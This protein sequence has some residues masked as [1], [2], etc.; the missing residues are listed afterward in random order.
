MNI[1]R[2]KSE[3]YPLKFN[4]E[5][6]KAHMGIIKDQ[7]EAVLILNEIKSAYSL[8]QENGTLPLSDW[9]FAHLEE[10][11]FKSLKKA[12]DFFLDEIDK[13]ILE[14]SGEKFKKE[15]SLDETKK[16]ED[17]LDRTNG[18]KLD[19]V[20]SYFCVN[21]IIRENQTILL[22]NLCDPKKSKKTQDWDDSDW[23]LY[24][25]ID[26]LKE[27]GYLELDDNI[28][29]IIC[30]NFLYKSK[31]FDKNRPKQNYQRAIG[32]NKGPKIYVGNDYITDIN[33]CLNKLGINYQHSFHS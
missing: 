3:K 2:I 21:N 28:E 13:L 18:V 32:K 11:A 19:A 16:E 20:L 33:T 15:E 9:E 5:K 31:K 10:Y 27:L 30:N 4:L 1:D 7:E 12:K 17:S 29:E 25:L 14:K 23:K 8:H 22:I 6:I 24:I 26:V